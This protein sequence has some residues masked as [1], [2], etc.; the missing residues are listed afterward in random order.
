MRYLT[1]PLD[2]LVLK[3]YKIDLEKIGDPYSDHYCF[4]HDKYEVE[5]TEVASLRAELDLPKSVTDSMLR[6]ILQRVMERKYETSYADEY[7]A[8][9]CEML[10]EKIEKDFSKLESFFSPTDEITVDG[11]LRVKK[12][13]FPN[14]QITFEGKITKLESYIVNCINGQGP[15]YYRDLEE[16]QTQTYPGSIYKR[17]EGHLHW[18]AYLEGIY[19]TIHSFFELDLKY[20]DYYGTMGDTN[21]TLEDVKEYLDNEYEITVA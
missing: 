16:F 5:D 18:L 7:H 8:K 12:I 19:G 6:N 9:V 11:G 3:V 17:I 2:K 10:K 13:D 4:S 15:F 1:L 20:V 21:Y 14:N